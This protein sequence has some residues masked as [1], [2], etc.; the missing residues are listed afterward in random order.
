V[1]AKDVDGENRY[2]SADDDP[3]CAK[4]VHRPSLGPSAAS[5]M[6]TFG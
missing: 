3:K 5:P 4:L 6:Q 1:P 2:H